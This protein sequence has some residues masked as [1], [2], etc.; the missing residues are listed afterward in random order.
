VF[1]W[2]TFH[3]HTKRLGSTTNN[4]YPDSINDWVLQMQC[5]THWSKN[6]IWQ[7]NG[8]WDLRG[9]PLSQVN[10]IQGVE[11]ITTIVHLEN[12]E[13]DLRA[14]AS[15]WGLVFTEGAS[16][17]AAPV[18]HHHVFSTAAKR[19][20]VDLFHKDFVAF[21]YSTDVEGSPVR[22]IAKPKCASNFIADTLFG[23]EK[24]Y[25]HA[26]GQSLPQEFEAHE[27]LMCVRNPFD[28]VLSWYHYHKFSSQVVRPHVK[29]YYPDSINDWVVGM[30]CE[31]HWGKPF[32]SWSPGEW[33]QVNPLHQVAWMRGVEDRVTLVRFENLDAD[34]RAFAAS[35]KL[36]FKDGASRNEGPLMRRQLLNST[37]QEVIVQLFRKDFEAFNYSPVVQTRS[38]TKFGERRTM[39][40]QVSDPETDVLIPKNSAVEELTRRLNALTD[41]PGAN[42]DGRNPTGTIAASAGQMAHYAWHASRP[43]VET[44]CESGFGFGHS[45][46]LFLEA[47]PIAVVISL[48]LFD[49]H[50]ES[51]KLFNEMFPGRFF[52]FVGDSAQTIPMLNDLLR[53]KLPSGGPLLCDLI[54][55]DGGGQD[56]REFLAWLPHTHSSTRVVVDDCHTVLEAQCNHARS[57]GM[58]QMETEAV[59]SHVTSFQAQRGDTSVHVRNSLNSCW[60]EAFYN[61]SAM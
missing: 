2:Y 29:Q 58:K 12:L 50:P 43:D 52:F 27:L 19:A 18:S 21:N 14:F 5:K 53:G 40:M 4:F 59:M 61:Q 30:L 25:H 3:K 7:A 37:A 28:L 45:S 33:N 34:L 46:A 10:W 54:S 48:D 36:A 55:V 44:I 23:G 35:R 32:H 39:S 38:Q 9:G 15:S 11:H 57:Y 1:S 13:H 8:K 51:L 49:A 24:S 47:N 42:I 6:G 41:Q 20:I 22:L 26:S 16:L 56:G 17:N 31:T 60:C